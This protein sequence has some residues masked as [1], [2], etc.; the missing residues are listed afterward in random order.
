MPN[1]CT[2]LTI[3]WFNSVLWGSQDAST[4]VD[5]IQ[6]GQWYGKHNMSL[7]NLNFMY[8]ILNHKILP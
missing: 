2:N 5:M 6:I 3:T 7:P 1:E 8:T 4:L